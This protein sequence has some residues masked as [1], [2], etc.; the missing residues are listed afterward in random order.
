MKSFQKF[1]LE[2]KAID[3]AFSSRGEAEKHFGNDPE[4]VFNN[5]GSTANPKWRRV[6]KSNRKKQ[7][8]TRAKNLKPLKQKELED[9]G[10]RNLHPDYKKTAR[11]AISIE[12][13]RKKSQEAERSQKTKET[14]KKHDVDH[15]QGQ[16]NRKKHS[17]RWHKIHPGDASDNRRVI[18]QADNLKKNSK[19]SG[20]KKITRSSAI[21]RALDRARS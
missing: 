9:H 7:A 2:A 17:D 11:K 6:K 14:G 12:R 1:I 13:G 18:T 19:D 5:A 3:E 8:S 4:Y 15:I 21:K 10:K 20:E 16:A